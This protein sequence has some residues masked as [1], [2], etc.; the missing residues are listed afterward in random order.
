MNGEFYVSVFCVSYFLKKNTILIFRQAHH[1]AP[2][3]P[4]LNKLF[5]KYAM[6]MIFC[7][8]AHKFRFS[9]GS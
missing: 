7:D 6:K 9:I 3:L 4:Q 8:L 2:P 1:H 5:I